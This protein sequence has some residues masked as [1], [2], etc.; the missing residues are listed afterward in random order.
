MI[1]R[2]PI[3]LREGNTKCLINK[4]EEK[5]QILEYIFMAIIT[6]PFVA[7]FYEKD[8]VRREFHAISSQ[9]IKAL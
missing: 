3:H 2:R 7:V 4:C 1:D 9:M 5:H 8:H 6:M